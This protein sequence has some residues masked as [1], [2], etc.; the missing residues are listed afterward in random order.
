M[1]ELK[2]FKLFSLVSDTWLE[3]VFEGALESFLCLLLDRDF[4]FEPEKTRALLA[5]FLTTVGE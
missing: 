2:E 5:D 1:F 4:D 3:H